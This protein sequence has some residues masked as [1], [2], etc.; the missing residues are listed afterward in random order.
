MCPNS[1]EYYSATALSP[2]YFI[3]WEWDDGIHTP[4]TATG[5]R[6]MITFGS[7]ASDINVYQVDRRTGCRSIPLVWQTHLFQF[8]PWPYNSPVKV[9]EGGE[10]QLNQLPD[11]PDVP[12]LYVWTS[13]PEHALTVKGDHLQRNVT[14]LANFC[15]PAVSTAYMILERKA[16]NIPCTDS[17]TVLLG[18]IDPPAVSLGPFCANIHVQLNGMSD[19]D[20]LN[21]D[22]SLSYWT[23][24]GVGTVYGIPADIVFPS[25]GTPAPCITYRVTGAKSKYP[26]PISK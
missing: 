23:I 22:Q 18:Q 16:C 15:D 8:A 6:V 26:S 10:F 13:S 4:A 21:A 3:L 14:V 11:H 9:C 7:A 2:D 19:D 5:E 24:N 20:R 1:S 17:V 25:A 12:V